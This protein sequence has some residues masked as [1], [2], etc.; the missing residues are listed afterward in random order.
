[1]RRPLRPPP[2]SSSNVAYP[3]RGSQRLVKPITWP[4]ERYHLPARNVNRTRAFRR[5]SG[6]RRQ[7]LGGRPAGH[8]EVGL[9]V[10][11]RDEG[12]FELRGG[13]I[14][15]ALEHGREKARI[16]RRVALSAGGV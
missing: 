7:G 15:A 10:G 9:G 8:V 2:P 4:R 1:V 5:P 11:E 3:P 12:G 13:Q 6:Q 16:P 14:H